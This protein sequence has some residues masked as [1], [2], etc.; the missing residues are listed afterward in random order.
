[1]KCSKQLDLNMCDAQFRNARFYKNHDIN[2]WKGVEATSVDIRSKQVTLSNDH[3]VPY[4]KLFI[5]TG[6]EPNKLSVPGAD[7]KNVFVLRHSDHAKLVWI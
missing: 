2:V 4:N 1:M 5:A 7:L 6:S 3:I